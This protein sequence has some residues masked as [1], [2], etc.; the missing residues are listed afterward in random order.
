MQGPPGPEGG[1]GEEGEMGRKGIPGLPVSCN[2]KSADYNEM[3]PLYNI[4]SSLEKQWLFK[5][6]RKF[7]NWSCS[8]AEDI[9][10]L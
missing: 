8:E 6:T 1:P 4:I 9:I 3:L 5:V 2:N 10:L 7:V